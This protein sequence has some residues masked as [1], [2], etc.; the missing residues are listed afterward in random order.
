MVTIPVFESLPSWPPTIDPLLWGGFLLVIA[1]VGCEWAGRQGQLPRITV[2][3]LLG[4]AAG[5]LGI[6]GPSD[7]ILVSWRV[8]IDIALGLLLFRLGG[9]LRLKWLLD[10]KWLAVASLMD[11][12]VT[13]IA[14]FFVLIVLG[15]RVEPAALIA[16]VMMSTSPAIAVSL[17]MEKRSRGQVSE[18]LLM[19]SFINS[20]LAILFTRF[21]LGVEHLSQASHTLETL[22]HAIYLLSGSILLGYCAG[23][24]LSFLE[25]KI[26]S[27]GDDVV[28]LLGMALV[29]VYSAKALHLSSL[30]A[31]VVAGLCTQTLQA[32]SSRRGEVD[33]LRMFQI[34]LFILIG[35]STNWSG[36]ASGS[37]LLI[38]VALIGTRLLCKMGV[39][40]LL[41]YPSGLSI[42]QGIGLGLALLPMAEVP[43]LLIQ[44]ASAFLPQTGMKA[45]FG[46]F[47]AVATFELLGPKVALLGLSK[48]GEIFSDMDLSSEKGSDLR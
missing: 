46:A 16:A 45:C 13:A 31:F 2:Y 44:D 15:V 14:I 10:N 3:T 4:M 48:A 38:G 19:I 12:A 18:R 22:L 24:A 26:V 8:F 23:R 39:S 25:R 11:S 28:L 7:Q 47:I 34:V 27:A 17:V 20:S 29:I 21:W 32:N 9:S 40:T 33:L 37:A 42:Q 35:A 30:F 1:A 36:L 41:A 6:L 5:A 43:L